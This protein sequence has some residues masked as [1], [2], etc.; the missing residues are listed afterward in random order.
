MM[1]N[2]RNNMVQQIAPA[3]SHPALRNAILPWT[4]EGSSPG[5][6]PCGFHPC[7]HLEPELPIAIKDQVFQRGFKG[8]R[9]PQL[10]GDPTARRMLGDINVQD[11]PPIMTDDEEAVEHA[12]RIRWHREEIHGRNGFPMVAK[13]GQPV[14]GP[15]RISRRSF[16]SM[17]DGSL[18]KSKAEHEEFPM[19]PRRSPS[20]VLNDHPEDQFP[21]L[22]R[23]L[24]PSDLPPDSGDQPPIH[25]KTCPV[26]AGDS[27]RRDDDESFFPS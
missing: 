9:L 22:L 27:F 8:K 5:N 24:F 4:P 19:N 7:D 15:V 20:W 1:F 16:H 11:P 26:P 25:T 18:G 14:L 23:C 3:T 12:E 13:E 17:G 10:L 21:N 6:D 2:Q